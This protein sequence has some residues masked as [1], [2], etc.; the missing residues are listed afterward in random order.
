VQC[1]QPLASRSRPSWSRGGSE[2]ARARADVGPRISRPRVSATL[3]A[4]G[5]PTWGGRR[6]VPQE[7][8][9]PVSTA[10]TLTTPPSLRPAGIVGMLRFLHGVQRKCRVDVS[11]MDTA[12]PP[13]VPG[14][15]VVRRLPREPIRFRSP[16]TGAGR[17][18]RMTVGRIGDC[19]VRRGRPVPPKDDVRTPV[20]WRTTQSSAGRY[21]LDQGPAGLP[22]ASSVGAEGPGKAG[23]QRHRSR[24]SSQVPRDAAAGLG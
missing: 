16:L 9:G 20:V 14:G 19:G 22:G 18:S 1:A 3:R 4:S 12:G 2:K 21:V 15:G 10:L 17:G 23:E 24:W 5:V 8:R 11:T 7:P 13:G 6:T